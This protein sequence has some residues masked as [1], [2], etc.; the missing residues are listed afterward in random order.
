MAS[1]GD[2]DRSRLDAMLK[3]GMAY[4]DIAERMPCSY[5]AVAHRAK[6]IGV[7]RKQADHSEALPWTLAPQHKLAM[8]AQRL[9]DLSRMGQG[10][11]LDTHK[12]IGALR[13]AQNLI[14]AGLDIGYEP[15][16][17]GSDFCPLG[18]FFTFPTNEPP[19]LTHVGKVLAKASGVRVMRRE[20]R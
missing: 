1:N 17:E 3:K 14:D 16:A 5:S 20:H 10:L 9:R 2:L 18:G 19:E 4:K 13:W 6:A 11:H 8:P 7:A 12:R 15:N